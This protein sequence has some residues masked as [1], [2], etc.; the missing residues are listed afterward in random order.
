M[1]WFKFKSEKN[2]NFLVVDKYLHRIDRIRGD[3][4]YYKCIDN[5]GGRAILRQSTVIVMS[6]SHNHGPHG[7]E[8]AKRGFRNKLKVNNCIKYYHIKLIHIFMSNYLME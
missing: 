1:E 7:L 8:L 6:K 4:E 3:N 5:C 2:Q